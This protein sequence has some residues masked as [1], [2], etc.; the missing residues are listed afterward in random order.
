MPINEESVKNIIKKRRTQTEGQEKI[1]AEEIERK[2]FEDEQKR[3]EEM[4]HT[5]TMQ[6]LSQR[7]MAEEAKKAFSE[8]LGLKL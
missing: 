6:R 5:N 7:K 3:K 8:R 4:S 2:K 1:L